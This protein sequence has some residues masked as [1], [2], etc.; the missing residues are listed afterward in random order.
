MVVLLTLLFLS[1][2]VYPVW[3]QGTASSFKI[4]PAGLPILELGSLL[5]F[6]IR[7]IFIIAGL[8]ALFYGLMGGI[9]WIT[10]GGGKDEIQAARDKIQAAVVG[11]FV[12]IVVL[13]VIWTLETV[14]FKRSICFGISCDIKIPNLGI[15][16]LPAERCGEYCTTEASFS[17]S[18]GVCEGPAACAA[19]VPGGAPAHIRSSKLKP[20][21][22]INDFECATDPDPAKRLCCC[23]P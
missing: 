8:A 18:D 3:A 1:P 12:L 11:I 7:L 9:A 20:D 16:P 5:T 22:T 13:T 10:S 6:M 23:V 19:A 14:V 21:G 17:Y 15:T 4:N 2:Q